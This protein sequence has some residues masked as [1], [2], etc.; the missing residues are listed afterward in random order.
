MLCQYPEHIVNLSLHRLAALGQQLFAKAAMHPIPTDIHASLLDEA[1]LAELIRRT[2]SLQG[3]PYIK[4]TQH[5][6]AGDL[7]SVY[8]GR[9]LDFEEARLYQP[10]DDVHDMDWRT[11]ARTNKPH[12]KI[13][14]EEHQPAL[15]VVI[16]RSASMRFGTRSQLKVTQAARIA[17]LLGFGAAAGNTC[18]G[19]SIWQPDAYTLPCRNGET[20][21]MQLI[22]AAIAPCPPLT[23]AQT[24]TMR[25][26]TDLLEQIDALLPRG[27]RIVLISDFRHLQ[28]ADQAPLLRLA[29]HHQVRAIQ[30]LDPAEAALPNVGLMRFQDTGSDQ[31]RWVDTAS[32]A[33]RATFQQQAELQQTELIALFRR[34]GIRLQRCMTDADPFDLLQEMAQ[35]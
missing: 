17:A 18:I 23:S 29:S 27:S 21:A 31:L 1:Q 26:F 33:V 25:P 19:G 5:R 14:R 34:I 3:M 4:E 13:Y 30:V 10:G 2:R 35:S 6:H 7:R 15:H 11:T 22:Q 28:P 8:L 24:K 16:D 32:H 9:G 20:G 12:I